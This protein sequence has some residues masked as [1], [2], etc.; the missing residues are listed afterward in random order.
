[1]KN[2]IQKLIGLGFILGGLMFGSS[3]FAQT[4]TPPVVVT[5]ASSTLDVYNFGYQLE[6]FLA[7]TIIFFLVVLILV[8]FWKE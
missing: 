6:I 7:G 1:M 8:L 4:T 5:F 2:W 3:V